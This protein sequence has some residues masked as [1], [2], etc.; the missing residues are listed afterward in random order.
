VIEEDNDTHEIM[1]T[2]I[3]NVTSPYLDATPPTA[4]VSINPNE[5]N[6]TQNIVF[7]ITCHDDQQL[8][9]TRLYIDNTLFQTWDT[10]GTQTYQA[11]VFTEGAH[12]YYV[13]AE[14]VAGNIGRDPLSGVKSFYVQ[15]STFEW[16][17]LILAFILIAG[18]IS[19]VVFFIRR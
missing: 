3:I 12:T 1:L 15:T 9:E 5:P 6:P 10:A 8:I 17:W 11:G 2:D 16:Q 4:S 18:M 19:I 13:E 14:D 7:T